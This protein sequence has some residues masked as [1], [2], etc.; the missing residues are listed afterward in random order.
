MKFSDLV[1]ISGLGGLY[2]LIGT[3]S[4]GAIV[5]NF[6]DDKTLFVAARKHE[7]TPLDSIEVYTQ[8]DNV[9]LR[10]VFISFKKNEGEVKEVAVHKESN[11]VIKE[12][13][14]KLFPDYDESRVYTSDMKK[15][16]KWYGI[17]KKLDLL[18]SLEDVV[19]DDET[20]SGSKKASPKTTAKQSTKGTKLPKASGKKAPSNIMQAKK[21][22]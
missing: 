4:D 16:L 9:S 8:T 6:D 1:S 15:M 21:G 5:K 22:S 17:L 14:S 12:T 11:E 10:D 20:A 7:V 13:F 2:Q 19:E 18:S 3:K